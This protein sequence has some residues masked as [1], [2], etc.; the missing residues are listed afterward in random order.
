MVYARS[1][2]WP[3]FEVTPRLLG[4][5]VNRQGFRTDFILVNSMP[6]AAYGRPGPRIDLIAR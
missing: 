3:S 4:G 6:G 5:R 2:N 1:R